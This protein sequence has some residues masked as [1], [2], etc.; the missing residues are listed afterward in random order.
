VEENR[1]DAPRL[2]GTQLSTHA[3][4][5]MANYRVCRFQRGDASKCW[6]L[7]NRL[8]LGRGKGNTKAVKPCI[9]DGGCAETLLYWRSRSEDSLSF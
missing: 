9:A 3:V 7:W 2:G 8:W 5:L 4:D 6:A 1:N